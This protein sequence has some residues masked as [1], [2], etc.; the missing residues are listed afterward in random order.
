MKYQIYQP[1]SDLASLVK[2][3]WTLEVPKEDHPR[4]QRIVP[5]GNI[6][7][8]FM[9][10]DDVKRFTS[11]ED[12]ILQ[13]RAMVIGQITEPFY[14]LP[15]GAVK[16]FG[17]CFYPFGFANFVSVPILELAN[18]ETALSS[19]FEKELVQELE[20]NIHAAE[21]TTA[22][23][24]CIENFLLTKLNDID[25]V[26]II[27]R[28][29]IDTIFSSKGKAPIN[30]ILKKDPSKKRQLERKFKKQVGLSPKQLSKVIRLQAALKMILLNQDANNL[31][32]IAYDSGFY[33]Q[34]HFIRDFKEF[35][36]I[37][38][39]QFLEDNEMALSTVFYSKE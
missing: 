6:E 16:T 18:R 28:S 10:G 21:D 17:A 31:T 14:I 24:Q 15:T 27:V 38:P 25:T 33:D 8:I 23:I 1:H 36:G 12:Y 30:S 9:L 39:K 5:D 37:N 26:D 35:T 2:F 34:S 29:T 20:K 3:Y 32:N 19:L 4:K 22:R 13:P 7:M 11:E